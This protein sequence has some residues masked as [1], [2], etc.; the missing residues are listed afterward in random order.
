MI[1][2]LET[3]AYVLALFFLCQIRLQAAAAP[4]RVTKT[5]HFLLIRKF[6]N[7]DGGREAKITQASITATSHA[8]DTRH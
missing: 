5:P 4:F 8:Y 7:D 2:V 1:S 6:D 3:T